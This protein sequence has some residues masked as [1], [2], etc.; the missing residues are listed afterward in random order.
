[1]NSETS[2]PGRFE[3]WWQED[4]LTLDLVE[5]YR[6][7]LPELDGYDA[8]VMLGGPMMPD[9]F[10][11]AP[12]LTR[13]RELAVAATTRGI[14]TLGICLGG[15]LIAQVFGG[16]VMAKHG[17]PEAGSTAIRL[18][19]TTTADP[20]FLGI[21]GTV[22]AIEHHEDTITKLP[23]NAVL[24]ASGDACGIQAFRVGERTWGLQFH[25]EASAERVASWSR[26]RLAAQG[27]DPD[28]V[29][30]TAQAHESASRPVWR[31]VARRF[32]ALA[33][34]PRPTT[35]GALA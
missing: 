34:G 15:Q 6:D 3:G 11:S 27:F 13:E 21:R 18:L 30:R 12:W 14:P 35:A 26:E 1:M 4:G 2:G 20:L 9:D 24:L 23:R 19:R 22:T 8:F 29:V 31:E 32:A 25:P 33:I 16:E 17:T 10:G 7:P 28:E 5:A